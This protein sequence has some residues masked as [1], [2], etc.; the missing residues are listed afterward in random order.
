MKLV[1][2]LLRSSLSSSAHPRAPPLF[3]ELLSSSRNALDHLRAP[4]LVPELLGSST[5]SSARPGTLTDRLRAPQL[6]PELLSSSTSSSARPGT[7]QTIN[8][9]NYERLDPFI[10]YVGSLVYKVQLSRQSELLSSPPS[11]SARPQ[12]SSSYS[13]IEHV[14]YHNR[15]ILSRPTL[16]RD[17]PLKFQPTCL[18][19]GLGDSSKI[20]L[21]KVANPR[22]SRSSGKR[23]PMPCRHPLGLEIREATPFGPTKL[24]D[25]LWGW[26]FAKQRPS[27]RPSSKTP[28]RVGNS[29]SNALRADQARR[30]PLGLENREATPFGPTKLEDTLWGWKIAMQRPSGR[31]SSKT[32]SGV[33]KSRSNA[34][35]ADQARRHPLGLENREATPF[36][37]IKLEDTLWGWKIAKQRPSGR[38]SSKTPSRGKPTSRVAP[39]DVSSPSRTLDVFQKAEVNSNLVFNSRRFRTSRFFFKHSTSRAIRASHHHESSHPIKPR[40]VS[41]TRVNV[42]SSHSSSALHRA[43]QLFTELLSSS[44]SSSALHRAPQ[45]VPELLSSS[46]SSSAR[47]R[48]P[49][50]FTELL[51]SSP[52]SSARSRAPQLFTELL[53]SSPS[54]SALRRAPQ[55]FT[56]L[57]SYSPSSSAL[58]RAPLLVLDLLSSST[59]SSACPRAPQ[60][61]AP[62]LFAEL[63]SSS[64]SSSA[65]LR[66]PLLVPELLSSSTS[67]SARPR[68]PQ[69][70]NKLFVL[71]QSSSALL[72]A[73]RLVQRVP[74]LIPFP[75][76]QRMTRLVSFCAWRGPGPLTRGSNP[77]KNTGE[78]MKLVPE[79]LRSSLSSSAHPR[80]PP[81]FHELLSSS[82][83]AL[84]H[85]RAPQ[86]VPELLG[87]STSSSARP[88]TLTDRLRAP[89][90]VPELLSSSTS[91][92]ARP[93]TPQ[94]INNMNYERLDPFIGYVG[95]LVYK[96]QLSRQSELLSSPPSSS[97]RPQASSS[98]SLIEHVFYHNRPILSR[99]TLGRDH[100]LKFQPT[101]LSLGL[102]II[103]RFFLLP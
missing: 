14:F 87:S 20:S 36:G 9:M 12:A 16:G 102:V 27:G 54:S 92:S 63:L 93:G 95:S 83:N 2:E 48:A 23:T 67:S 94:T 50:L 26:K 71:S 15:P 78:R 17:H 66:A 75:R 100:P 62:Q 43:P 74:Q 34:L 59:S 53:N 18:S 77:R 88:G 41:H 68:A 24:E 89:Q 3:H 72:K 38:P 30:H 31:S 55:L 29:R 1:P 44:Q 19:L 49:Q 85:L 42:N 5:S 51:S 70:F 96:V 6:V 25:T 33:G 99:P 21:G 81:L 61:R 103:E 84:D 10:G 76:H 35:R 22:R 90:L 56:K 13:L 4:Q 97:A 60:L 79:L 101:C 47:P 28:S 40:S 45:L 80:A 39:H 46:P 69:L 73:P 82:R 58:L 57:L 86:L 52:S 7:P 11:S 32:P 8:N 91:S 65:L 64:P 98:Y 37:P